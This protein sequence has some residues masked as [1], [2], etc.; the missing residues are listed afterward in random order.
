MIGRKAEKKTL[1]AAKQSEYSEF[2]AVYGRRRVGKTFLVRETFDYTFTFQHSG[3][4]N[5]TLEEQLHQFHSAICEQ[6]YGDCP[7]IRNWFD[8]FDALKVV[9]NRSADVKKLV[10]LDELPFMDVVGSRLI[11]ALEHFW[12]AWASARKD[13]L[14]IICGSATSWVLNNVVHSRGGLHG[15]VTERIR[16]MPFTL[17]ECREYAASRGL[18]MTDC[19][20]AEMYMVLGGIPY[21]WKYLDRSLSPAQ[22]I[23]EI[24]FAGTDK[25]ENEFQELYSSLFRKKEAYMR[26]VSALGFKKYGMDR[27]EISASARVSNSGTLTKYLQELE[28]CGFIRK[29]VLPGRKK[30]GAIY[31]LMDN[32]T[33]FHFAFIANNTM[34]DRHFWSASLDSPFHVVWEGLAFERLCLWHVDQIKRALQIGGVLTNAYA[35]RHVPVDS[36]D[37]G[38]QIDLLIDRNDGIINLCEMKFCSDLYAITSAEAQAMQRKKAAFKRDS[39]TRKAVHVTYVT[40]FGLKR[41]AYAN[42]VQSEVTLADLFA[43]MP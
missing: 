6:G 31:Q 16:L 18:A 41:N 28:Q 20:L 34:R 24:F 9:I 33:L 4:A 26:I 3:V 38:A 1:L 23:D 7:P 21:Y 39:A 10:F 30:K 17:A 13:V 12:N 29:Y 27:S 35:W 11:P 15:R 8:A 14:L 19:Q 42:D 22:N 5:G 32:F 2:V 43:E 36:D 37:E 25:L 40:T